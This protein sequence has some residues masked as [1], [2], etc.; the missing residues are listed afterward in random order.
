[1]S[2]PAFQPLLFGGDIN[3]YSVARAFHEAYGVKSIAY[4]KYISFPCAYSS[5]IDYR[6]CVDNED[7]ETFLRNVKT[8]AQECKDKTVLVIGCGDSYVK[9]AAH[10][11]ERF[12]TNVKCNYISGEMLDRL[13]N[14]EEFYQLCDRYGIDHPAT[15][16]YEGAMGHDFTLPWQPPYIAKPADGVAYWATGHNELKKV[17]L[18]QS[19]EELLSALDEVYAAG[20]PGKMILQEFIPGDDTYMRVLTNYSDTHGKVKLMCLGHVL[21][22][23]HSPHGIGNHAVILTEHDEALCQAI[24]AMLDGKEI[25]CGNGRL[26]QEKNVPYPKHE[27]YGTRVLVAVDGVYRGSLTIADTVKP[28]SEQAVRQLRDKGIHTVMLTGDAKESAQAVAGMVGISEVHAGLLPH[29]KLERLQ[30][31]R[32]SSGPVMFVG[33][34][35]NDAPVLAGADVGAAM[36]SGADAA[37]EA[38]D[39]VFMT[40]DAEAIPQAL[41]IAGKTQRIAWQNVI[42]ALGVKLAVMILGLLGYANMWLAVFADSGVAMLCV[43]NSIRM[44]YHKG[45]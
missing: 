20:Y 8:V 36:G 5:I 12:P 24:R 21:L 15:F 11:R 42:F 6:P 22:E 27:S 1:M 9:L 39:V 7:A 33:D 30:E 37:I 28:G 35:I 13:T 43:L 44:L 19:W 32:R 41:D 14:K 17:Y 10:L 16:V 3:V 31:V 34:G 45:K 38:A 18:C 25:L 40:S 4:G 29:Q 2:T 26:L 23:E